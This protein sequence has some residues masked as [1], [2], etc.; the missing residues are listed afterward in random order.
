[1]LTREQRQAVLGAVADTMERMGVNVLGRKHR[2]ECEHRSE[3]YG[4]NCV[5]RDFDFGEW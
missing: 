5:G 4:C 1:M 2:R 3:V